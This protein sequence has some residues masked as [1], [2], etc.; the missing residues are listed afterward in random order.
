MSYANFWLYVTLIPVLGSDDFFARDYAYH[1]LHQN[2]HPL[3]L[4][5]KVDRNE[6]EGCIR[7]KHLQQ[8]YREQLVEQWFQKNK[9]ALPWAKIG[10]PSAVY[11][12]SPFN[13]LEDAPA[14]KEW[15]RWRRATALYLREYLAETLDFESLPRILEELQE[16]ETRW[17]ASELIREQE[18]KVDYDY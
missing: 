3:I 4:I 8:N 15:P 13:K 6:L 16:V 12:Q 18:N 14:K 7:L 11:L 5:A 2:P 9:D 10:H 1:I 17:W